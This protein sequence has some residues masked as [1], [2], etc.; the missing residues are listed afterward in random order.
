MPEKEVDISFVDS[1]GIS[2]VGDLLPSLPICSGKRGVQDREP[3]AGVHFQLIPWLCGNE[4]SL[5]IDFS[6]DEWC[7]LTQM[8]PIS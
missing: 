7:V 2:A 6:V 3:V 5:K 4:Y 8:F 1:P